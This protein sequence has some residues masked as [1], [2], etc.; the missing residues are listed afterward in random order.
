LK[1]FLASTEKYY[2][3]EGKLIPIGLT[4]TTLQ[5]A[6]DGD[7]LNFGSFEFYPLYD[8]VVFT[9]DV[10]L[11]DDPNTG[12]GGSAGGGYNYLIDDD[13]QPGTTYYDDL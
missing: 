2:L 13:T 7:N 5:E 3:F 8:D 4:T 9:D 6:K 1:D 12:A 11:P 10:S